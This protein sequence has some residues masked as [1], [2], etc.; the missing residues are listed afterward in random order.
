MSKAENENN[1]E[2]KNYHMEMKMKI[3]FHSYRT[4]E[5]IQTKRQE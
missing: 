3:I 1:V 5:R 4:F 2:G